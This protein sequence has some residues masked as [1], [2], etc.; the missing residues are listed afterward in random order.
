MAYIPELLVEQARSEPV[1]L[2]KTVVNCAVQVIDAQSSQRNEPD[3]KQQV[4]LI[5]TCHASADVFGARP[6]ND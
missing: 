4:T 5:L 1:Y 6:N 2:E 3:V